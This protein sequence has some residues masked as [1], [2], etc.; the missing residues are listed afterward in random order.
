MTEQT[1]QPKPPED[2]DGEALLEWHRVCAEMR[3]VGKLEA[4][5]RA[6]LVL[7]TETWAVN[8]TA[9]RIV[10]KRGP[11]GKLP[12]DVVCQTPFYKT[13][14]ETTA[15]LRRLLSDLGLTP[16]S[17]SQIGAARIADELEI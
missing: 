2:M 9:S 14:R 4:C 12:N 10:A 3:S 13:Q 6:L 1:A 16:A 5:D 7:Y 11:V 15:Q 8:R 17:R